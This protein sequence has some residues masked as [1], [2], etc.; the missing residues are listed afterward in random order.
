MT[1]KTWVAWGGEDDRWADVGDTPPQIPAS[2]RMP[3]L[4]R[5]AA[6]PRAMLHRAL[7][8]S[9]SARAL[10]T[11]PSYSILHA[12]SLLRRLGT[13]TPPPTDAPDAPPPYAPTLHAPV[14]DPSELPL[15]GQRWE[16]RR[17]TWMVTG[18]ALVAPV[19]VV[20]SRVLE[21][22]AAR[23]SSPTEGAA[24]R[25]GSS[26]EGDAARGGSSSAMETGAAP[27]PAA[28]AVDAAQQRRATA[29]LVERLATMRREVR[30][31][32]RPVRVNA[33]GIL[34]VMGDPA[35]SAA[36]ITFTKPLPLRQMI[37]IAVQLPGWGGGAV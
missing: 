18:S 9:S 15:L 36:T 13:V 29:A 10:L 32:Q 11:P 5:R 7:A 20:A 30:A 26:V 37:G 17:L 34:A 16:R 23:G 2:G 22:D 21:G 19:G 6:K 4:A 1:C 25:S 28:L 24:A 8:S 33:K 31:A 3:A 14:L 27:A 35:S 12:C